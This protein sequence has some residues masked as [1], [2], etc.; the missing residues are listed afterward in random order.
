MS[1]ELKK[2]NDIKTHSSILNHEL[3]DVYYKMEMC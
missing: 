2:M 3:G 1:L